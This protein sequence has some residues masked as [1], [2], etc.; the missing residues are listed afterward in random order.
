MACVPGKWARVC[1]C[2]SFPRGLQGDADRGGD[3]NR[4]RVFFVQQI[5]LVKITQTTRHSRVRA[6]IMSQIYILEVYLN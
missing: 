1:A 5:V 6:R 2:Q 4:W 3:S